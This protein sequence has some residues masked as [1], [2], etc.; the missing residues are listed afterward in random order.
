MRT[1]YSLLP[2]GRSC[3][4]Y[5]HTV[6]SVKVK[7]LGQQDAKVQYYPY[8]TCILIPSQLTSVCRDLREKQS[9]AQ[10]VNFSE[11]YSNR[12]YT[13][14]PTLRHWSPVYSLIPYFSNIYFTKL[15]AMSSTT[16]SLNLSASLCLRLQFCMHLK[17]P[18]RM[19]QYQLRQQILY[20]HKRIKIQKCLK[21]NLKDYIIV[22]HTDFEI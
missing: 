22:S 8:C 12:S 2:E 16:R 4:L 7:T 1:L 11:V 17:S 9:V 20:K 14:A 10:L 3:Y 6:L 5:C 21:C 13:L 18:I 15:A 19:P